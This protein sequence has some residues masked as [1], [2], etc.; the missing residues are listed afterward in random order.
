M[1]KLFIGLIAT[2]MFGNLGFGQIIRS[3]FIKNKTEAQIKE[4]FIKLSEIEKTSLWIQKIDHLLAQNLPANDKAQILKAKNLLVTNGRKNKVDYKEIAL[5]LT[6]TIPQEDFIKMFESLSDYAYVGKYVGIS[7]VSQDI[8][9]TIIGVPDTT[10][11]TAGIA[12]NCRWTCSLYGHSSSSC[13]HTA[14]GCG[15][16]G[17]SPCNGYI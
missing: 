10:G 7:K 12:C 6:K 14:E 13:E 11:G 16:L 17:L 15:F 4:S 3:N 1:K 8:I 5:T 2:V 9:N